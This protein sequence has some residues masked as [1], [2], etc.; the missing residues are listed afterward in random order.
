MTIAFGKPFEKVV[1][2]Y[3]EIGNS[4]PPYPQVA[5]APR[6]KGPENSCIRNNGSDLGKGGLKNI[7]KLSQI[8]KQ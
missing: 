4:V 8:S 5:M 1:R 2:H 6:P 3:P 7:R